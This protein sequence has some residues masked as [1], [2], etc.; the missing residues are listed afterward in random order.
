LGPYG[1][2][3]DRHPNLALFCAVSDLDLVCNPPNP[4]SKGNIAH[5]GACKIF[6]VACMQ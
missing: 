2:V 4:H 1:G 6:T 5:F 3:E